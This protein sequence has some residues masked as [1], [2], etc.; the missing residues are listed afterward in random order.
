MSFMLGFPIVDVVC[1]L[2]MF[3]GLFGLIVRKKS[4]AL[5]QTYFIILFLL[6]VFLSN[7]LNNHFDAAVEQFIFFLKMA[8][9]FFIFLSII[10]SPRQLKSAMFFI[11]LLTAFLAIQS[12][13]QS[14]FGVGFAGQSLTPGYQEIRVRWIGLWDGPNVLSLLFVIVLPFAIEF[15]LGP[16]SALWRVINLSLTVI[17]VY[18]IYL[19]NSRGGFIAFLSIIFSYILF[20]F[21]NKKKAII[22]GL[23]SFVIFFNFLKPSRMSD[24]KGEASAHER[25]WIWEQG[26]NIFREKPLFGI[27]RGQFHEIAHNNF[28]QNLT[29]TGLMG[30]FIYVA[31]MYLSFKGLFAALRM[32]IKTR[33]NI[34]MVPLIRALFISL[35]G[36]NVATFF[37]NMEHDPLFV[38]LGLCAAAI[39]IAHKKN[40]ELTFKF[41]TRDALAVLFIVI[42]VATGVYFA[43]IK[44]IV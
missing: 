39:N 9:I 33:K 37:V 21:R 3:I 22:V 29:E 44:N 14:K 1:G 5:P 32:F 7:I 16:Y 35:L 27:G 43:A 15:A 20:K 41:S 42:L 40:R 34:E 13:Y 12:I 23:L 28:V 31:L 10:D 11:L 25:T 6:T 18:G 8:I 24:I 36:F 4:I 17:L 38:C 19:T 30:V 26:F 2:T